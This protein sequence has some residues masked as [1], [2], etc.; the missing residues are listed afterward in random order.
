VPYQGRID[1]GFQQ[2]DHHIISIF[3][4]VYQLL[5][6][7]EFEGDGDMQQL[8]TPQWRHLEPI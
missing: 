1:T 4:S 8:H 7:G 5:S 6:S 2:I 3:F